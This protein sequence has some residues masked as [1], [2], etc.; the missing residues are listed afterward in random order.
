[1]RGGGLASRAGVPPGTRS[2]KP[3]RSEREVVRGALE[4]Q[5]ARS[6]KPELAD[7]LPEINPLIGRDLIVP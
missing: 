1:M 3:E 6:G 5:L 2:G 4:R 7:Y